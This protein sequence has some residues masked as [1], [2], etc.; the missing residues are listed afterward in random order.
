M[1]RHIHRFAWQLE[2]SGMSN[3]EG[4]SE[5]SRKS[6]IKS[7]C[8]YRLQWKFMNIN[9][10]SKQVD[11]NWNLENVTSDLWARDAVVTS[12]RRNRPNCTPGL[13]LLAKDRSCVWIYWYFQR[14]VIFCHSLNKI[15]G[16]YIIL[17]R[18]V[19]KLMRISPKDRP[20]IRQFFEFL[21]ILNKN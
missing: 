2:I 10:Y 11:W 14:K 4:R 17:M 20:K 15:C 8:F 16:F 18:Y 12:P 13:L 5:S 6:A 1:I 19:L 9:Y 3:Y 21:K 7:H